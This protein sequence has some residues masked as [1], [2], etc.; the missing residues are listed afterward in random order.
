MRA[1]KP[2]LSSIFRGYRFEATIH[3]TPSASSANPSSMRDAVRK[4]WEWL[5]NWFFVIVVQS[6]IQFS[7]AISEAVFALMLIVVGGIVLAAGGLLALFCRSGE[8]G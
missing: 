4:V 1:V 2:R 6:H 3:A 7:A 5:L 8:D